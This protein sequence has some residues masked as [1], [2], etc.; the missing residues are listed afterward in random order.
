MFVK[1]C[2]G[3]EADNVLSPHSMVHQEEAVTAG[4]FGIFVESR[5]CRSQGRVWGEVMVKRSHGGTVVTK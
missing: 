4:D 5:L 1:E 3:W 2:L